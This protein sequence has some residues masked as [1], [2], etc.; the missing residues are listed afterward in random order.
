MDSTINI[1]F[2]F[3][4]LPS[5]VVTDELVVN[6]QLSVNLWHMGKLIGKKITVFLLDIIVPFTFPV[7]EVV[8]VYP[9]FFPIGL[10][11]HAN[12]QRGDNCIKH[13]EKRK[14]KTINREVYHQ[15]HRFLEEKYEEEQQRE[16]LEKQG[17]NPFPY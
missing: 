14:S 13:G 6:S 10:L 1:S 8:E 17:Q 7:I 11:R 15:Y 4:T 5:L 3:L 16:E 9:V 12:K 2:V